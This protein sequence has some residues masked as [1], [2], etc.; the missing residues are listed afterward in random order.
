MLTLNKS[1]EQV[2]LE[3]DIINKSSFAEKRNL[4]ISLRSFTI[5]FINILDEYLISSFNPNQ[6]I[7][8]YIDQNRQ[9]F[10]E[11]AREKIVEFSQLI[12]L[13]DKLI[14]FT[15]NTLFMIS[16][17]RNDKYIKNF[18]IVELSEIIDKTKNELNKV[19]GFLKL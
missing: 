14:M 4:F 13:V 9:K 15:E 7:S 10:E 5:D 12:K 8:Q 1:I 16:N 2:L 11:I 19:N 17:N 6:E 18:Q 3:L